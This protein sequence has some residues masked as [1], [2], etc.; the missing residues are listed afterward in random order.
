MGDAGT[1]VG[2]SVVAA[3][4]GSWVG[5]ISGEAVAVSLSGSGIWVGA[6]QADKKINASKIDGSN[7]FIVSDNTFQESPG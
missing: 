4:V 7:L 3:T 1:A 2:A 6:A 5:W